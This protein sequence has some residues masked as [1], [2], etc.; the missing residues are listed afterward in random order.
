MKPDVQHKHHDPRSGV[1]Y[2][3]FA[4]R[5]LEEH[6]IVTAVQGALARCKKKDW[7]KRGETFHIYT[8]L[9]AEQG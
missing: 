7:P 3:V 5:E 4:F 2:V 9:G 1:T 6:E 8:V